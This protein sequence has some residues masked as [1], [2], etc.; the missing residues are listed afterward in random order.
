MIDKYYNSL[1]FVNASAFYFARPLWAIPGG[2]EMY[3][4]INET[5]LRNLL[6][7]FPNTNK[8]LWQYLFKECQVKE[9]KESAKLWADNQVMPVVTVI[10][11]YELVI[12]EYLASCYML[13]SHVSLVPGDNGTIYTIYQDQREHIE[14]NEIRKLQQIYHALEAHAKT[15][16]S[17]PGTK[18]KARMYWHGKQEAYGNM[19]DDM[20]ELL[21]VKDIEQ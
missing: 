12:P 7:R 1:A 2:K 3:L 15:L 18:R 9:V 13:P 4:H 6:D 21:E 10:S 8:S 19:A 20:A 14:P 11:N 17:K 16:A 5:T